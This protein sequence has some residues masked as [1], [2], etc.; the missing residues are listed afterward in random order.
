MAIVTTQ[1]T[2]EITDVT[3]VQVTEIVEDGAGFVRAIR[4]YGS[5]SGDNA[6][7]I[8]D[9]R[10]KADTSAALNVTTPVFEF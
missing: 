7:L 6:P 3:D 10:I 4:I 8:L 9:L 5:P 2:V 1:Q